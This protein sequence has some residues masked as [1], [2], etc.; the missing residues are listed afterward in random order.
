MAQKD[1]VGERCLRAGQD[2]ER[3]IARQRLSRPDQ[4]QLDPPLDAQRIKIVEI[5]DPRE[6]RDGDLEQIVPVPHPN[7][8]P[9]FTG[10]LRG[11]CHRVFGWQQ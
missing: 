5:G 8:L 6:Q 1:E 10:R 9:V 4:H 3:S 7:P 2:H 11:K